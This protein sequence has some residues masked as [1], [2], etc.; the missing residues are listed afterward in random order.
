MRSVPVTRTA[1]AFSFRP[2]RVAIGLVDD[3]GDT[4]RIGEALACRLRARGFAANVMESLRMPFPHAEALVLGTSTRRRSLAALAR[5]VAS[6]SAELVS[7]AT[8]L[9]IVRQ[10]RKRDPMADI[11]RV[12]DTL[13]W[14]PDL[15]AAL[16]AEEPHHGALMRWM[17]HHV[18]PHRE[19]SIA[20]ATDATRLADSIAVGLIRAA[21]LHVL[22]ASR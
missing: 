19:W 21:E 2:G 22:R 10:R 8:A 20:S 17:I 11:E 15:A 18:M 14:R 7:P 12:I 13:R 6:A 4:R 9:F 3:D 16:D 1:R 5:L